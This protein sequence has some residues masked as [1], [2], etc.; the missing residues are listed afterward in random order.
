MLTHAHMDHLNESHRTCTGLWKL[1]TPD[2]FNISVTLY[3]FLQNFMNIKTERMKKDLSI[4]PKVFPSCC[5][6]GQ[7]A[8]N[9][10]LCGKLQKNKTKQKQTTSLGLYNNTHIP[11]TGTL[12]GSLIPVLL[13]IKIHSKLQFDLFSNSLWFLC[14]TE[15]LIE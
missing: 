2:T 10:H 15:L 3:C 12:I 6:L 8:E 9:F 13:G 7:G 14:F 5:Q 1:L 11:A 4:R